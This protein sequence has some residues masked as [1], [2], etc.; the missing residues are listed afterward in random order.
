[1]HTPRMLRYVIWGLMR[2]I[3]RFNMCNA[4]IDY[5]NKLFFDTKVKG[6]VIP[7]RGHGRPIG[8]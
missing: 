7:V 1:M 3:M 5:S 6:K 2:D 4:V 8:L